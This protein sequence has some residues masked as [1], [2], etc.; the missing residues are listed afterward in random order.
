MERISYDEMLE[1]ASLGAGVMHSR[2]IEFAKKFATQVHVRSSFSDT[3]GTIIGPEP[4]S[5]KIPVCGMALEK[6]EA[7][8]TVAGVP[9]VPGVVM[10]LFS[11][12]A[13]ARIPVDMIVQSAGSRGKT[14]IS[15]TVDFPFPSWLLSHSS[16]FLSASSF[17]FLPEPVALEE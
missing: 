10:K 11:K 2:S 16:A 8:I 12:I 4:E 13:A 6:N 5:D 7:R 9:D 15:F 14:D 17:P 1:M 3:P